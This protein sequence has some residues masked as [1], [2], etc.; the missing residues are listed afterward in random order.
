MHTCTPFFGIYT[1][2]LCLFKFV[3]ILLIRAVIRTLAFTF[4]RLVAPS[5]LMWQPHHL[6]F[7]RHLCLPYDDTSVKTVYSHDRLLGVR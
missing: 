1:E 4:T 6:C 5:A 3:V 2:T 7:E